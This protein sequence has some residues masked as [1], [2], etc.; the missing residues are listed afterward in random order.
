MIMTMTMMSFIFNNG[1]DDYACD[2]LLIIRKVADMP[3]NSIAWV[4]V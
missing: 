1:N 3:S 2:N 4:R